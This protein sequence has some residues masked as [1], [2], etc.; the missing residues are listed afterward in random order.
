MLFY[1]GDVFN[2]HCNY[3]HN[4]KKGGFMAVNKNNQAPPLVGVIAF[5][6]VI[7]VF[8]AA[9]FV[10]YGCRIEPGNGEIAVLIKK[11]GKTL[12]GNEIV[13][14][15]SEY[16]GIQLEVLGEGRYFRNPY[17]WD[18]QIKPVTEIPAG[19]SVCWSANSAKI[20]PPERSLPQMPTAK[21]L[22]AM[23]WVP[24]DTVSI[25]MPTM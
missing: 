18:W 6:V 23:C 15:S 14:T 11:T 9:L 12:P 24:A 1:A 21:V 7:L 17:I 2:Y 10:W 19:N 22:S 5:A 3:P 25:L 4:P 20:F 16:K 13:A 8:A